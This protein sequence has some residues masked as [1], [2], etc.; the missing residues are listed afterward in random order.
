MER[1]GGEHEVQHAD[2]A[3]GRSAAKDIARRRRR[4]GHQQQNDRKTEHAAEL[5]QID[6]RG[7]HRRIEQQRQCAADF[8]ANQGGRWKCRN[9]KHDRDEQA[10]TE[11]A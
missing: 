7:R 5:A 4:H 8:L 11:D 3:L 2:P 10:I 6:R 9:E 1:R